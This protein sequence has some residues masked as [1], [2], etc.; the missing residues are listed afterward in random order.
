[1]T[2]DGLAGRVEQLERRLEAAES[3]LALHHLK[4]RYGELVDARFTRGAVVGTGLLADLAARAAAL[5]TEDGV[6]DGGPALGVARGRA[7]IAARLASPTLLFSR[8]LFVRPTISV[9]G[10]RAAARWELLSPCTRSDGTS[11]W[12]SGYEDDV[13]AR[14]DGAWLHRSMT[15]TTVFVSPTGA[16]WPKI[17][18]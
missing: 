8:H 11:M 15:L 12:M 10:P 1:M 3:V 5:F 2:A 9:E 4:A 14:I 6:W 17:L 16:G 18:A 7:E 13:Y